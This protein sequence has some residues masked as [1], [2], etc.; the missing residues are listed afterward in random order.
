MTPALLQEIR[1]WLENF[2]ALVLVYF[3]SQGLVSKIGRVTEEKL[4]WD[5]RCGRF[6]QSREEQSEGA[7]LAFSS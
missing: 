2:V 3:S 4:G 6:I 5:N 1:R 7:T